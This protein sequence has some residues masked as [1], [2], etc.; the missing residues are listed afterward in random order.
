MAIGTRL[1][2]PAEAA[3]V[4]GLD[5]KTVNNAIDNRSLP[6]GARRNVRM[7][8]GERGSV[9]GRRSSTL[10]HRMSHSPMHSVRTT[11]KPWV[12]E[13]CGNRGEAP[14]AGSCGRSRC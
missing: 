11:A 9:P 14:A 3:V 10:E 8:V 1:F 12:S 7:L 6:I 13:G 4:T 2:I 5:L